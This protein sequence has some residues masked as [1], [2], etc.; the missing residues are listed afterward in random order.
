MFS[1]LYEFG[2]FRLDGMKRLLLFEAEPVPLTPKAFETLLLLVERSGQLVTKDEL[3]EKLWPDTFVEEGSLTRN[4]SVLRKALGENPREHHY[5]V[6]VPGKG[7][8]FVAEVIEV[9]PEQFELSIKERSRTR[10]VIREGD[11]GEEEG[12]EDLPRAWPAPAQ[13]ASRSLPGGGRRTG[14]M[15]AS[16]PVLMILAALLVPLLGLGVYLSVRSRDGARPPDSPGELDIVRLTTTGDVTYG[17]ISPDGKYFTHAV[18][19][20]PRGSTLWVTQIA[21]LSRQ[22]IAS[23]Q[24]GQFEAMTFSPDGDFIYYGLRQPGNPNFSLFRIATLGGPSRRVM[25]NV[26]SRISFSP[27]GRRFVFS[28][29][30]WERR[31]NLLLVVNSDGTEEQEIASVRSPDFFGAPSWSPNGRW[32][33]CA[34]GHADGGINR[35]LIA[36]DTENWTAR[37]LLP[38]RWQWIND[39]AWLSDSRGLVMVGRKFPVTTY[40][41]WH[42]SFP[43]GTTR[44]IPSDFQSYSS[45]LSLATDSDALLVLQTRRVA[46]VW[47]IPAEEPGRAR[48]ITFGTGGYRGDISWAPDGRIVFESSTAGSY[49]ISIMNV[50]ATGRRDLLGDLRGKGIA[51]SPA[52]SPDGRYVVFAFDLEGVRNLWRVDAD[53]GNLVRLTQGPGEDQPAFSP[54]GRWVIHTQRGAEKPTLWKVGV[55]GGPSTQLTEAATRYPAVSP[56]GRL[57]A[58]LYLDEKPDS[59]WKLAIIPFDGGMPVKVFAEPIPSSLEIGWN[60]DGRSVAYVQ[61]EGGVSNIWL[62][63]VDGGPPRKFTEFDG[64]DIFGFSWSRDGT[65]LACIRGLWERNLVLIRNFR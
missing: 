33:A 27:D 14:M 5:I 40:Q 23:T 32:I 37:P 11:S 50:D 10:I 26:G 30:S 9:P 6:T 22:E 44:L 19:G 12:D 3:M 1:G 52:A 35:Y 2:P 36:I 29:R 7:Y 21:S 48:K 42:V 56:D 55:D 4:I 59:L 61:T 13:P 63:P 58:C 39:V 60:P 17:A 25:E 8:Q 38:E 46:N 64:E 53:G 15:T 41:I 16:G 51:V 49:D 47:L 18:E 28:R 57:I 20:S 43:E 62:Q 34:A 65:Q 54:D 31:E 45:R 24:E